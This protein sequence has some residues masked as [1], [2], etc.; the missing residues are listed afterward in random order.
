MTLHPRHHSAHWASWAGSSASGL[1]RNCCHPWRR[2]CLCVLSAGISRCWIQRVTHL[3]PIQESCGAALPAPM[4]TVL[5]VWEQHYS[6]G[7]KLWETPNGLYVDPLGRGLFGQCTG[8]REGCNNW[9]RNFL[10]T[11]GQF[12]LLA[13]ME[14]WGKV[15]DLAAVGYRKS[16]FSVMVFKNLFHSCD[17]LGCYLQPLEKL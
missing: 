11:P 17:V 13:M 16:N 14:L 12:L 5:R 15:L 9:V 4:L 2:K 10:S 6:W 1:P 7:K 3:Q 8:G